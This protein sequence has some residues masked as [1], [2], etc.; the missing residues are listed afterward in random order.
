MHAQ[1]LSN[2]LLHLASLQ[3][4]ESLGGGAPKV[5]EAFEARHWTRNE[6]SRETMTNSSSMLSELRWRF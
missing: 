4:L 2:S 1:L 6:Q 5:V 3:H